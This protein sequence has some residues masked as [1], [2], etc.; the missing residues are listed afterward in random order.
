VAISELHATTVDGPDSS[1]K[2][3]VGRQVMRRS[4]NDRMRA[5]HSG[6][7]EA[8]D[9]FCECGR[10][11]C[12]DGAYVTADLYDRLRRLPT[13][14]LISYRHRGESERIVES[15]GDFAIVEKFGRPGLEAIRFDRALRTQPGGSVMEGAAHD[16]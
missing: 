4:V 7:E 5:R 1:E 8:F 2:V 14:F 13:H 15:H 10:A 6:S 11:I 16:A 3:S 9:V 12:H